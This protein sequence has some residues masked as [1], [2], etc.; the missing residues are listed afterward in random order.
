MK[1]RFSGRGW[2][3]AAALSLLALG[4]HGCADTA[5]S[6]EYSRQQVQVEQT[7]RFGVVESVRP[8]TIQGENTGVGAVAGAGLGGVAGSTIGH[9]TGSVAGAI[10]G[11]IL[12]G[13]AGNA[14]EKSA[15]QQNGV[16][17]TVRLDSGQVIAVT[18][19]ADEQ[20]NIGDRVRVLSGGGATRVSH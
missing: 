20:F 5:G 3:Q 7:V 9:N 12:G 1:T 13:L 10:G 14:V 4:L 19:G 8:V 18:Q 17:I 16:E 2:A 15:R 11:A 6:G